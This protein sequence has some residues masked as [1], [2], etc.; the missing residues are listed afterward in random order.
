MR[1]EILNFIALFADYP[2]YF[3][4]YKAFGISERE[5]ESILDLPQAQFFNASDGSGL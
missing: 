2:I 5:R 3:V 1:F 4:V